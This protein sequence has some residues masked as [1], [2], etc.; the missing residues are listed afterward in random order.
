MGHITEYM[1]TFEYRAHGTGIEK[2]EEIGQSDGVVLS[3]GNNNTHCWDRL[4]VTLI[5]RVSGTVGLPMVMGTTQG[6]RVLS[7]RAACATAVGGTLC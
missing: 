4:G 1:W 6:T 5:A 3:K 2:D 7:G